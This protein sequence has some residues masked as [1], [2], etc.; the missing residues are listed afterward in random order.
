MPFAGDYGISKNPESLAFDEYRMY[1]TDMQRG[2][3]LRLS[4]NGVTPISDVG[5][6]SYFRENLK[7]CINL[8]GSFDGVNGEYNLTLDVSPKWR[9]DSTTI[10]FNENSKGWVSFKSFTPLT[11][12]SVNDKY[13]TVNNNEVWE[14]YSDA[15]QRNSFYAVN[16]NNVPTLLRTHESEIE[17]LFNDSPG[18]VKS[19]AAVNYE[20]S[21]AKINQFTT[22]T[23]ADAA[24]NS[25]TAN[26][27]EYY[28]IFSNKGGWYIENITT[29]LQSGGVNEFI[30]KEN[31]WFN[32]I[33]GETTTLSNLDTSEITVQGIGFPLIDPTDTQT[34]QQIIVQAVDSDGNPIEKT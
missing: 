24:G 5:M 10:S 34:E 20:G 13:Y 11:A 19:F 21:Q 14:H 3:V 2:A 1:F 22:Q 9:F 29:D 7:K 8:I 28:N 33:K 16:S 25:I 17:V 23:V 30:E 31:K 4:G 15:A 26:D 32:Y 27:C 18:S 12:I 6:K